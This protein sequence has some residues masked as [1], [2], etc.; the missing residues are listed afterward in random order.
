V[1]RVSKPE[2]P[3]TSKAGLVRRA[4]VA[5]ARRDFLRKGGLAAGGGVAALLLGSRAV[6]GV[7]AGIQSAHCG[8]YNGDG[9]GCYYRLCFRYDYGNRCH[10]RRNACYGLPD[11]NGQCWNLNGRRF[12]DWWIYPNGNQVACHCSQV[13]P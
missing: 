6:A 5:L 12:C 1:S 2:V 4:A 10:E 9:Y 3:R 13:W 11:A 7:Q 8:D